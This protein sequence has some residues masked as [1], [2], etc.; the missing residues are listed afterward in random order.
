MIQLKHE[1]LLQ[2]IFLNVNEWLKF[3]EIKNFGLL[4][5]NAAIVFGLTQIE[6]CENSTN[7]KI[8]FAIFG[9]FALFS[10]LFSLI[11]LFSIVSKIE[12]GEYAKTFINKFSNWIDT[13]I[14]FENIHFYGYLRS[15]E[16]VEFETKFLAK[17]GSTDAFSQ[18]EKELITQIL[19]NSRVTW[20][21]Y[22]LFKIAAFFFLMGIL[23][24]IICLGIFGIIHCIS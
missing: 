22:Q 9:I 6:F 5:L 10:F 13:E 1:E 8:V 17:I 11:S 16:E 18:Y 23:S 12:K 15:I 20:L 14:L 4:S 19:Y 2:K 24:T 7:K 21:K 3:A